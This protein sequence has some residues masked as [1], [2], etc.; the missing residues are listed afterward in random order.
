[1]GGASGLQDPTTMSKG[2]A[3][4]RPDRSSGPTDSSANRPTGRGPSSGTVAVSSS[5]SASIRDAAPGVLAG[6]GVEV[7]V[8]SIR[9]RTAAASS[10]LPPPL[11][12]RSYGPM[13]R[14]ASVMRPGESGDVDSMGV[15]NLQDLGAG[16]GR[17]PQD[18]LVEAEAGEVL[19]F[20]FGG[21]RAERHHPG[22][23]GVPSTLLE[24]PPQLGDGVAQ[25]RSTDGHPP[26]GV[27]GD[28]RE[29]ARG[30]GP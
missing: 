22:Q 30:G 25:A 27:V 14:G 5:H 20:G 1:M 28:G 12:G 21:D 7:T 6:A 3:A 24:R 19:Q 29:V 4:V 17:D 10:S 13:R 26:V 2:M 16:P 23:S 9:R 8:S 15:E 11:Q 18:H